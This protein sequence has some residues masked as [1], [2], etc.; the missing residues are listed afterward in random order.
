VINENLFP[1]VQSRQYKTNQHEF[2]RTNYMTSY[3]PLSLL[4]PPKT[5][6]CNMRAL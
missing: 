1:Q 3:I 2:K 5:M 6:R 4:S